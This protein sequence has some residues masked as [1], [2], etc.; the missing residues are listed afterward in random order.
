MPSTSW[1]FAEGTTRGGFDEWLCLENPGGSGAHAH[2]AFTTGTG[3]RIEREVGLPAHSRR[4]VHVNNLVG[5]GKDVSCSVTSDAPI[6]AERPMYFDYQGHWTGGHTVVGTGVPATTWYF[7]EGYTGPGFEEWVCVLNPGSSAAHL[8]FRFQTQEAGEVTRAAQSVP[9]HSRATFRVND[10]LGPGYQCSLKLESDTPVIAERPMY[11]DYLGS[12]SL[13]W[14]GGH[15]VMGATTLAKQYCF[16]EGTTRGGFEEWLTIQN[17]GPAPIRVSA[18]FQ[19][20]VGQGAAVNKTYIVS[21]GRRF[22]LNVADEVGSEKDVSVRL[23]SASEFLAERPMYFR[24]QGYGAN[25]TGGHCVVGAAEPFTSCYFAE[26]YTGGSFQEYLCLQ[27]PGASASTVEVTYFTQEAGALEPKS[28]V[29]PPATR[30]TLRVND[31]AGGNYQL[32]CRL[33]V[34]SGPPV[35][36]ERP[37]YFDYCY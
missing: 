8:T 15:C 31:H 36:V 25:M 5:E 33:R 20:G 34:L 29:V 13:H 37:M 6:V 21:A 17:P 23:S 28:V 16:A 2:L 10:L 11:F 32:S 9:A 7:A 4:T 35:V 30:F 22:T 3:E 14:N 27:N 1:Y 12:A 26:G 18:A 24:Y 19:L